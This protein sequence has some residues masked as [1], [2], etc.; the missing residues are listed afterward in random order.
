MRF[1]VVDDDLTNRK[2]LT[3]IL[4]DTGT[5]DIAVNGQEA[6]DYFLTRL[7]ENKSYDVIFL[8][9]KMP[10]MDGHET[11]KEIRA[12]EEKNGVFVGDG[13]K[14]VMVTALG[15]KK[16]ILDAFQEGCEYYLVKPFQQQKIMGLLEEMGFLAEES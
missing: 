5:C 2:L 8:D 10:V 9:I 6:V 14:I 11:L 15:D 16:N 13:V 7:D 4:E 12:I 1:L 3:T